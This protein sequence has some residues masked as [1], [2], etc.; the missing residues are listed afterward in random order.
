MRAQATTKTNRLGQ[1]APA[2]AALLACAAAFGAM[3]GCLGPADEC[4]EGESRCVQTDVEF[5]IH[6]CSDLY[7]WSHWQG[8]DSCV[9]DGTTCFVPPG[10]YAMCVGSTDPDPTCGT[11]ATSSYC[12]ADSVASCTAGYR[13]RTIACGATDP[14]HEPL[15]PGGIGATHCIDAQPGTA[16]C[17]PS[18]AAVDPMCGDGS[19]PHC[20]AD[21][22]VECAAGLAV[23]RTACASCA[24]EDVTPSYSVG[25]CHGYLG[26]GCHDDGDC[27]TGL[28]CLSDSSMLLRCTVACGGVMSTPDQTFPTPSDSCLEVFRDGGPP[29][30]GAVAMFVPG[31]VLACVAGECEWLRR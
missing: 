8:V 27:A 1:T 18:D 28:S 24:I 19:S 26:D 6:E 22:L 12:A 14:A 30:S 25:V 2:G 9:N 23:S 29:P 16:T 3:T 7:C 20:D 15:L 13:N 11:G 5:C 10:V 21:V 31:N 4:T 17:V